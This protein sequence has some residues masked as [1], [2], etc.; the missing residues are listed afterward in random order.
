MKLLEGARSLEAIVAESPSARE[1]RYHQVGN[2][3]ADYVS[4]TELRDLLTKI[5]DKVKALTRR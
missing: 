4:P 1:A 3:D 2:A 5:N